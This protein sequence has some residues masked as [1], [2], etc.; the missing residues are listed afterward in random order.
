MYCVYNPSIYFPAVITQ[1]IPKVVKGNL[2]VTAKPLLERNWL[3]FP[4][5]DLLDIDLTRPEIYV[6]TQRL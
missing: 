3:F 5:R 1:N 2:K 6:K 4:E